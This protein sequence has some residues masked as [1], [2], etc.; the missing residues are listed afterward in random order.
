MEIADKKFENVIISKNRLVE[1]L[2]YE[3]FVETW[4]ND[5]EECEKCGCLNPVG[6]ICVTCGHD[7]SSD[8]IDEEDKIDRD[9]IEEEILREDF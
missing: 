7:S 2:K 4:H 8:E 5:Y 6:C 3:H 1:L 9:W